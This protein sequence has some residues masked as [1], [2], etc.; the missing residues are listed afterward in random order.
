M[1]H[2]FV[3]V[4]LFVTESDQC[5]HGL[6]RLF[7]LWCRRLCRA[8]RFPRRR[9]THFVFQLEH[10]S[11]GCF[12]SQPADFRKRS[13]VI[14]YDRSF[15]I[16]H[17]HSTQN[18]QGQLRPNPA[19]VIHQEPKQIAFRCAQESIQ[20]VGVLA[21]VQMGEHFDRLTDRWK[22]VVARKGNENFVA[23]AVYLDCC[24]R[25][26]SMCEPAAKKR[27]HVGNR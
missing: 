16:V 10:D 18:G 22:L 8:G 19:D 1:A 24:L 5:K 26:Q 27:D 2:S 11:L 25:W 21:H 6:I 13:D 14:V 9:H 17:T 7:L 3:G 23:N 15:E 20:N 12:L 4:D